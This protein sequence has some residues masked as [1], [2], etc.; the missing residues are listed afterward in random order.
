MSALRRLLRWFRG[1]FFCSADRPDTWSR[2]EQLYLHGVSVATHVWDCL[3]DPTGTATA[4]EDMYCAELGE[5]ATF[6]L[7]FAGLYMET[8]GRHLDCIRYFKQEL[9]Q[10]R[11]LHGPDHPDVSVVLS[12]IAESLQEQGL[13][14]ESMEVRVTGPQH[15]ICRAELTPVPEWCAALQ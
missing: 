8:Q 7:Y 1:R 14:D 6:C 4:I 5:H 15:S 11:L 12:Y 13:Y 9:L 3:V 10:E 2:A